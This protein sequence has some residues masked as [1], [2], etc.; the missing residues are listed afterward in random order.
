MTMP[1]V[2]DIYQAVDA[3][4]PYS[5]AASWD[6]CGLQVGDP[7]MTVT[8][9][10][11]ALD[12]TME[13]LSLAQRRGA[14]LLLTHHPVI[15]RP[16]CAIRGEDRIAWMLS[17]RMAAVSA[18]TN[19]DAAEGGVNDALFAALELCAPEPFPNSEGIG[20]IGTLPREMSGSE[21]AR[22]LRERLDARQVTYTGGER[23]RR[24][25]V[26]SGA[27]G[28]LAIDARD[29]GADALITGEVKHSE[30]V[31]AVNLGFSLFAA[32][33]HETERVVLPVLRRLL[34]ER[35][36]ELPCEVFDGFPLETL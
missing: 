33:H 34:E 5:L 7:G 30:W 1:T 19:L 12:V 16:L 25:A 3:F 4:A 28:D 13:A 36:P 29:A 35:F 22:Y 2:Q 21:L 20:K 14:N 31:D 15:F 18:H 17:H 10:V 27:C 32:G 11:I 8:G 26:G 23:I 6:N 9:C 24:V